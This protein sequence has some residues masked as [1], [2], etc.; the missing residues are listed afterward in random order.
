[1]A[2]SPINLLWTGGWDSTFRLLDLVLIKKKTVQ[3]HYILDPDRLSTGMELKTMKDIKWVL[4]D[5]H[6]QTKRQIFPTIFMT[7]MILNQTPEL[8]S[9]IKT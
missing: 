6:Q 8:P 9:A 7:E 2:T 5:K 1:M 3:P 4:F